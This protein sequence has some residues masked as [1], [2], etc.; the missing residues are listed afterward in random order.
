[1]KQKSHSIGLSTDADQISTMAKKPHTSIYYPNLDGWRGYAILW[2]MLGHVVYIYSINYAENL[3]LLFASSSTPLAVDIFFIISGYVIAGTLSAQEQT[4][5]KTFFKKRALRILPIYFFNVFFVFIVDGFAPNY[6][7]KV[8]I[9][10]PAQALTRGD[11]G[12]N[13]CFSQRDVLPEEEQSYSV[14][15]KN[16]VEPF[17]QNLFLVQNFYPFSERVKLLA[18]TWFVA[19][20]VHFYIIYGLPNLLITRLFGGRQ[21]QRNVMLCIL[22]V[23][24]LSIALLRAE[25]GKLYQEYFQMTHFRLDAILLG[26]LLNLGKGFLSSMYKKIF[27]NTLTASLFFLYWPRYICFSGIP[28]APHCMGSIHLCFYLEL[29]RLCS[30]DYFYH[31]R[32]PFFESRFWESDYHM[33]RQILVRHLS[34]ALPLYVFLPSVGN[35]DAMEQCFFHCHVLHTIDSY[36]SG[37]AAG[38]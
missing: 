18:H 36:W 5:L 1:M 16:Q 29:F 30:Y 15:T 7:I 31:G 27:W 19:I 17:W 12:R 14:T 38:L 2:I 37:T 26:C 25:F 33:D 8:D 6:E 11:I 34:V 9:R 35:Q 22:V 10:L 3:F 24:I 20:I 21:T 13:L 32:K 23:L 28:M 4:G